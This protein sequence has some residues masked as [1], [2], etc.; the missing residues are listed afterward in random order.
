LDE[1][2]ADASFAGV[3]SLALLGEGDPIDAIMA[4]E[5]PDFEREWS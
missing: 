1:I 5:R 3:G 2:A 4:A